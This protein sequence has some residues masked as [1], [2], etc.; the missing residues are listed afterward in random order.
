M[1]AWLR[2]SRE[3]AGLS[4][5]PLAAELV[6]VELALGETDHKIKLTPQGFDQSLERTHLNVA[7]L[8]HL[9]QRGLPLTMR[10]R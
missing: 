2:N 3:I 6:D 7:L 1:L 4:S 5:G 10:A 9:G 8:L